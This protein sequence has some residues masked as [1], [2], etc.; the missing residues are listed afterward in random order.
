MAQT[1]THLGGGIPSGDR[2]AQVR[3]AVRS[4]AYVELGDGNGGVALNISEGGIA[5]Q[6][7]MALNGDDLPAIRIQLA[8][9]KKQ[10]EA[11][12]RVAWTSNLRRLAGVEFADLSDESRIQI[13]EWI[14]LESADLRPIPSPARHNN[15]DNSKKSIDPEHAAVTIGLT[16]PAVLPEAGAAL[17]GPPLPPRFV[18][19]PAPQKQL[20][21]AVL[22]AT[23]VPPAFV[24]G[25]YQLVGQVHQ[26]PA[27]ISNPA[28]ADLSESARAREQR[29]VEAPTNV[30]IDSPIRSKYRPPSRHGCRPLR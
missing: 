27:H 16:A 15:G 21:P 5:I 20:R 10:I 8:H 29:Q 3:Q 18:E 2:R 26:V 17:A 30:N 4:L 9:A 22:S 23:E 13:R 24:P 19:L 25:P 12:G 28:R 6:A 14:S 1:S 7:V 11:R